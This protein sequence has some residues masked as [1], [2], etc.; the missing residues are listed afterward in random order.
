MNS[1]DV[2]KIAG[3]SRSTVSRVINHYDNV[4]QETKEKVE[5]VIKKYNYVPHASARMLAGK[6]NR[7]LGLFII[8]TK[9]T[10][11]GNKMATSS[12]F[13]PFTNVTVDTA[14]K[15]KYNVL[16]SLVSREKDF[17][18]IKRLFYNESICGGIFIGGG[19]YEPVVK[20]IV[21]TGFKVAVVGQEVKNDQDIF[22]KC[23]VINDDS[24]EGAYKATK[25]LIN[26]GHK[27]IAHITGDM[28]QFTAI[29]RLAGYKKAL[30]DS[31]I[32]VDNHLIEKGNFTQ[33][34][35]YKAA[36]KLMLK[37]QK[38]SAVFVANDSMAIG[39][40]QAANEMNIKIPDDL[41]I[42][43]F[44]DIE[45]AG[46]LQPALTTVHVAMYQMASIAASTLIKS[47]DDNTKYYANY[48]I[49]V[50]LIERSSCKIFN[51]VN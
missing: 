37:K 30:N 15:Q 4:P 17:D 2:A 45:L 26:L 39:V 9:T 32:I 6:K 48:K 36:K 42:I 38:P 47:N 1:W 31:G 18:N 28:H 5:K 25:Y 8:D 43:G 19:N 16:I 20:E 40:I 7:T 41:S 50:K 23:I 10:R 14:N 44:D 51:D 13:S 35:G 33:E 34:S 46:Y 22:S 11:E 24:L 3:V 12:Y 27:K 29:Q 49:P 21:E